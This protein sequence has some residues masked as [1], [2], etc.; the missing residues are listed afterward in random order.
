MAC[1]VLLYL[2][3]LVRRPMSVRC[4]TSVWYQTAFLMLTVMTFLL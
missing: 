4:H 3:Y 2:R 1:H